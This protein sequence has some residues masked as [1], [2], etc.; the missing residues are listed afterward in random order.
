[1]GSVFA[2]NANKTPVKFAGAARAVPGASGLACTHARGWGAAGRIHSAAPATP[3]PRAGA[4]EWAAGSE[5]A[6]GGGAFSVGGGW[7]TAG[8]W[9]FPGTRWEAAT[10]ATSASD[11]A[12]GF[13][14][15]RYLKSAFPLI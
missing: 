6:V 13:A 2:A 10:A 4:M 3:P 15:V 1:M 9:G 12:L 14:V 11:P 5:P 8:G 7:A